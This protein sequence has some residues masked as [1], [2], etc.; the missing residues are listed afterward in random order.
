LVRLRLAAKRISRLA[1]PLLA[2]G[3]VT[4]AAAQITATP[5]DKRQMWLGYAGDHAINAKWGV[6]L[7]GGFRAMAD[8]NWQQWLIR[9]GVNYQINRNMQFSVAYSY[10]K[11]H[12]GGFDWEPGSSPEHRLHQQFTYFQNVRSTVLR[13][14]FR[15]EERWLGCGFNADRGR[16]WRLQNRPRYMARADVPLVRTGGERVAVYVA[17][18]DEVLFRVGSGVQHSFEQNRLY[19]GIGFR[20][21]RTLGFEV[22]VINQRFLPSAGGR[23]ENN[24]LVVASV[25]NTLSLKQL[26]GRGKKPGK[27]KAKEN[28][29]THLPSQME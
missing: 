20:P 1:I 3:A 23:F 7:D 11:T 5:Y 24:Y 26:F 8:T 13:H 25:S 18:S 27:H 2:A 19:G 15:L 21:T 10:F 12:P 17:L 28:P 14:R 6:H 29:L 22:G 4:H 16:T 9:P